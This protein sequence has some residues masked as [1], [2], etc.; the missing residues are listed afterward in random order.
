MQEFLFQEYERL[1]ANLMSAS[2]HARQSYSHAIRQE[3]RT[4][5]SGETFEVDYID[6][7]QFTP[8]E[9]VKFEE[10]VK[11]ENEQRARLNIFENFIKERVPDN[12]LESYQKYVEPTS[13]YGDT[14][15]S[16]NNIELDQD[17]NFTRY[18]IRVGNARVESPREM[19]FEEYQQ[20]YTSNLEAILKS[21]LSA[22]LSQEEIQQQIEQACAQIYLS[23]SPKRNLRAEQ[24]NQS[25]SDRNNELEKMLQE[26]AQSYDSSSSYSM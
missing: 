1:Q 4:N 26:E 14:T 17:G 6:L 12:V 15:I 13:T 21:T 25:L 8:E 19:T 10:C 20:L 23:T 11:K 18:D 24:M 5:A 3:T 9:R 7:G 22:N 16:C 2:A